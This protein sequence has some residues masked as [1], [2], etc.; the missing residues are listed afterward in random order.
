MHCELISFITSK[1]NRF[2]G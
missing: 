2:V 1:I